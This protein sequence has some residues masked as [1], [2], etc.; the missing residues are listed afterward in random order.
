MSRTVA[1]IPD[2]Q[3][4]AKPPAKVADQRA[5]RDS[6]IAQM[7]E[8]FRNEPQVKVRIRPEDGSQFV[9][10]NGYSYRIF[11]SEDYQEVPESIA[12]ELRNRGVI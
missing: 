6:M 9:Q 11:P 4:I 3:I 2:D 5:R 10:I 1:T 12:A 7:R 8:K